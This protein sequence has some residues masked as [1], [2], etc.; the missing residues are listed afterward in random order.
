MTSWAD[1]L[2]VIEDIVVDEFQ[3][4]KGSVRCGCLSMR[5][6]CSYVVTHYS[7]ILELISQ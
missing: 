5:L 6:P 4:V 7:M 3:K 1:A 2:S